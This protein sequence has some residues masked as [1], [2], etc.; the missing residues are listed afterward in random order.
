LKSIRSL[1]VFCGSRPGR[2]PR[3]MEAARTLGRLVAE[4]GIRL[5][6]GGGRAGMM[7]AVADAAL[8]AGG[9]VTGVIPQHLIRAEHGH[10][11]VTELLVVD[12]MHARKQR[13]F[14]LSDAFA[15]LPGGI[16]TLDEAF[17]I[18]TWKQLG[19]HDKP[20]VIVDV[21]GYWQRFDTL[22]ADLVAEGFAG[23]QTRALYTVADGV[24]D[25]FNAIARQ[26][27]PRMTPDTAKL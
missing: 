20:I 1:C 2:D 4:S 26:P 17:E 22:I 15:V 25:L 10:G 24:G 23:E 13:M 21:A 7:G 27:E 8:A 3:H 16:G 18:V 6:F 19:I 12:S 14:E 11:G 5:V 9:A